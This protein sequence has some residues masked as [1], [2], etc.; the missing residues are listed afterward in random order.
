MAVG[1]VGVT[2]SFKDL[3]GALTN[4]AFA[5][6]FPLTGGNVG[7]GQITISMTTSRTAHQVASD[8]TVMPNYIPGNNGAI[9][10]EVQQTSSLH[11]ALL[12]LY[13]LATLAAD[14]DDV[15]GWAST[16]ISFRTLLDGSTHLCDGVSFEKVPDKPYH[17]TGSNVTWNL[18]AANIV[19]L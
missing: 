2:Y 17:A 4:S 15:S 11:H 10:I 19:N 13:N 8:G 6:A 14:G 9:A 3:V 18:M 16:S 7:L 1:N 12:D 5:V